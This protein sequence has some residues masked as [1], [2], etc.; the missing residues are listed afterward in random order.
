[1]KMRTFGTERGFRIGL[2]LA[3]PLT[4]LAG[5]LHTALLWAFKQD[6][7]CWRSPGSVF[8]FLKLLLDT[9][10]NGPGNFFG[11]NYI[12]LMHRRRWDFGTIVYSLDGWRSFRGLLGGNDDIYHTFACL[13]SCAVT[14]ASLALEG[15]SILPDDQH[16]RADYLCWDIRVQ[17]HLAKLSESLRRVARIRRDVGSGVW[18]H[19]VNVH[20]I[21]LLVRPE[22]ATP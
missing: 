10:Y 18:P 13:G 7:S 5:V 14:P 22:G 2:F 6:F 21:L 20:A 16:A 8:P 11:S 1:M 4:T 3:A 17:A 15:A 19:T 12:W 9:A